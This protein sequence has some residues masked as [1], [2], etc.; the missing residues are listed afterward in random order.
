[1]GGSSKKETTQTSQVTQPW[2]PAQPLLGGILGQLG[3]QLGQVGVSPLQGQALAGLLGQSGFL[4][5]FDPQVTGLANALLAGGG[6]DRGGMIQDAYRQY[7]AQA[8]PTASGQ[9]TDPASNPFYRQLTERI[10]S[11][12]T[13]RVSALYAGAGRDPAGAGSYPQTLARGIAEGVAPVAANLYDTERGR[14]LA[15]QQAL[16]GAGGQTAGLLSQLDQLALANRQAG[17][18]AAQA[19]QGFA[20]APFQ[21]QLAVEAQ[22]LGIPM[23]QLAR[24]A[25]LGIP[26]AGL[27]SRSTGTSTT[28][29]SIPFN[30]LQTAI[31]AGLGFAGLLR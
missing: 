2:G 29:S 8:G 4:I 31:G 30:P 13:N 21:Q 10:G 20:N 22:R 26:I 25:Q 7:L 15:A 12:V 19:A 6:P 28:T 17:I 1:M 5:Q 24:I 16:Y 9:L 3:G 18:G 23:D 27:G 11:D 14:Q